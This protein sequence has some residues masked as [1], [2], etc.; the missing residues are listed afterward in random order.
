MRGVW[1]ITAT[2]FA[3]GCSHPAEVPRQRP[4]VLLV[5]I[6]TLRA[7]HVG[8]YG[9]TGALTPTIDGLA[10]DGL[11]FEQTYAHVPMTL[12]SHASL[13]TGAYPTRNGVRDNGAFR[14][15]DRQDE[16]IGVSPSPFHICVIVVLEHDDV[17]R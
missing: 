7:D 17:P 9:E 8:A 13:L 16:P 15:G 10:K 6:D 3:A 1:L 11:R 5:T 12:P 14:I 4:N 2:L